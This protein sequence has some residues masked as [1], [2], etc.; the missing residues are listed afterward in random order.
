MLNFNLSIVNRARIYVKYV[1]NMPKLLD[2]LLLERG[3]ETERE[4]ERERER[5]KED[6]EEREKR[7]TF[8]SLFPLASGI[9]CWSRLMIDD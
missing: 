6:R 5:E 2:V 7:E 4:R 8:L 1:K 9:N 3:R